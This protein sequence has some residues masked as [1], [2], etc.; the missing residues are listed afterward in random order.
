MV[1]CV[2]DQVEL[3]RETSIW[4][5]KWVERTY[6]VRSE[7]KLRRKQKGKTWEKREKKRKREEG[8]G[9]GWGWGGGEGRRGNEKVEAG[10]NEACRCS[11]LTNDNV[12]RVILKSLLII[13]AV[14]E[15]VSYQ[16]PSLN[17]LTCFLNR[18]E[19]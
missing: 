17:F 13:A 7:Y 10:W 11:L 19:K 9:W 8:G 6:R 3:K 18:S 16:V 12:L 1:F 5:C 15:R 4:E 14:A 2:I